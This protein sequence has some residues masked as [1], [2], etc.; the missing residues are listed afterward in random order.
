MS[1]KDCDAMCETVKKYDLKNLVIL[2]NS[3]CEAELPAWE[4]CILNPENK[5][6]E[7]KGAS[8]KMK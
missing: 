4:G 8:L 5:E 6:D 7:F 1:R 2:N 3:S